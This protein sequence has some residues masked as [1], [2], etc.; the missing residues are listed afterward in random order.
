[1]TTTPNTGALLN[2]AREAYRKAHPE[3]RYP[4]AHPTDDAIKA[5]LKAI[6][7]RTPAPSVTSEELM[8][9]IEGAVGEPWEYMAYPSATIARRAAQAIL[10]QFNVTKK[11]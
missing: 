1:M 10:T 9:I 8:P 3:N 7:T 11:D 2:I 4:L 5:V 6:D